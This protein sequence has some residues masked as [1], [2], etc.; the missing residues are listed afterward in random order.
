MYHDDGKIGAQTQKKLNTVTDTVYHFM[1][2]TFNNFNLTH[3]IL[4]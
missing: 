1:K 4:L 3:S 2:F